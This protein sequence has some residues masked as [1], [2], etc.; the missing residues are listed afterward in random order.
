[1]GMHERLTPAQRN[2]LN[3]CIEC[4]ATKANDLYMTLGPH[5][6]VME[7]LLGLAVA[8]HRGGYAHD[9]NLALGQLWEVVQMNAG[10]DHQHSTALL[11]L[12]S[13]FEGMVEAGMRNENLLF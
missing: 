9:T 8:C 3:H 11:S 7:T 1:M 13:K 5:H 12:R 2:Q 4:L 6:A 10:P